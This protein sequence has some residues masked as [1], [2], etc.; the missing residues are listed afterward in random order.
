MRLAVAGLVGAAV[1]AGASGCSD[2]EEA[3]QTLPSTSRTAASPS[4]TLPPL[5]PADFPVPAEAR[6]QTEAG[7]KA[8]VQYYL[9]LMNR[10]QMRMDAEDLRP[11]SANCTTCDQFV[12]GIA[13]YRQQGYRFDG[14]DISLRSASK[15]AFIEQRVD[16]SVNFE[17]A[18]YRILNSAGAEVLDLKSEAV[19]YPASGVSLTWQGAT[20]VWRV[21]D[22][23]IGR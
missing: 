16:I 21:S 2:G 4:E 19:E 11:F 7:A 5:G 18:P 9:E 22:L 14:G 10:A 3:S 1:L 23:T 8:F 20:E 17:Q 6:Q 12:D 15:P 13:N